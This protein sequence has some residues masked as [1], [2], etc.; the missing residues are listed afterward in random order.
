MRR[1]VEAARIAFEVTQAEQRHGRM[2]GLH[3]VAD[4]L[5][6]L[7]EWQASREAPARTPH[8][9][10]SMTMIEPTPEVAVRRH[11]GLE[12]DDDGTTL[13]PALRRG[14]WIGAESASQLLDALAL[15]EEM[16]SDRPTIA[17]TLAYA[18]HRLA[19]EGQILA[20]EPWAAAALDG[21]AVNLLRRIQ[22]SVD[23]VLSGEDIRYDRSERDR[24]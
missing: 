14:R 11:A 23:R 2:E 8:P 9:I 6:Y 13:L 24:V 16:L 1:E 18:L 12:G 17:R 7:V 21:E 4:D 19:F 20:S 3:A 10:T 15:L 22:E 5:E